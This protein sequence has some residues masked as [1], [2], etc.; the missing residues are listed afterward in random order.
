MIPLSFKSASVTRF[1]RYFICL[2]NEN[3]YHKDERV[4]GF[5]VNESIYHLGDRLLDAVL[6]QIG[7]CRLLSFLLLFRHFII[8]TSYFQANLLLPEMRGSSEDLRGLLSSAQPTIV[9]YLAACSLILRRSS[10]TH[11]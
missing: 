4:R 11:Q 8:I 7:F 9:L 5:G 1:A 3:A 6:F 2:Q 10:G